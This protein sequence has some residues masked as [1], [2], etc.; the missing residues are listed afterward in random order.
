M[1]HPRWMTSQT[2][3]LQ[4]RIVSRIDSVHCDFLLRIQSLEPSVTNA[5]LMLRSRIQ[6]TLW[7]GVVAFVSRM[8]LDDFSSNTHKKMFKQTN[9]SATSKAVAIKYSQ[10]D[11]LK[12]YTLMYVVSRAQRKCVNER[13]FFSITYE[14]KW[15][16]GNLLSYKCTNKLAVP[17]E[18]S[19][20]LNKLNS[21]KHL[22]LLLIEECYISNVTNWL[23]SS[24]VRS[25][26]LISVR[27]FSAVTVRGQS[28][29]Y[30]DIRL[31][32]FCFGFFR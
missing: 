12:E 22:H 2:L 28:L 15:F 6:I 19:D 9:N 29:R 18:S 1:I 25:V 10:C 30:H 17:C 11:W 24:H 31:K 32:V 20:G 3:L 13:K 8:R 5:Y 27:G 21:H 7:I 26:A 4:Q 23:K 16:N 14:I